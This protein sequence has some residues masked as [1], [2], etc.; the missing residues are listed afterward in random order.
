MRNRCH[1]TGPSPPVR[2]GRSFDRRVKFLPSSGPKTSTTIGRRSDCQ[3]WR[4][5]RPHSSGLISFNDTNFVTTLV[6]MKIT[7]LRQYFGLTHGARGCGSASLKSSAL[8]IRTRR[9]A[10]RCASSRSLVSLT[11]SQLQISRS[12]LS[13]QSVRRVMTGFVT[14]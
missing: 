7:R 13:E 11:R 8:I 14:G 6:T 5:S 3:S 12:A 10:L 1:S 4:D 9:I 2:W